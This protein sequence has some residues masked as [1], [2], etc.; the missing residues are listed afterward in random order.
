MPS[1]RRS[2]DR[3]LGYGPETERGNGRDA[4]LSVQQAL[5]HKYLRETA[6]F[7]G[8]RLKA[9]NI[10]DEDEEEEEDEDENENEKKPVKRKANEKKA[11]ICKKTRSRE[12]F[13]RIVPMTEDVEFN[14]S[15]TLLNTCV[16][17]IM[18]HL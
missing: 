15:S 4:R 7:Y 9:D 6:D 10:E 13:N 14:N 8:K 5:S 17:E 12:N 3:K 16:R 18:R 1:F 11:K 2:V